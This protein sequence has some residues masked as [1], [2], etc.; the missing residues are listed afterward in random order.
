MTTDF[1]PIVYGLPSLRLGTV[2]V[3]PGV[4]LISPVISFAAT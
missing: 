1:S 2:N 4:P 3:S